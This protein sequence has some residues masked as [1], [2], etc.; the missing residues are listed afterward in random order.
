MRHV[1]AK[2]TFCGV[3]GANLNFPDCPDM[4]MGGGAPGGPR[5]TIAGDDVITG[6]IVG[7]DG[8]GRMFGI[9]RG[10]G[11]GTGCVMITSFSA[12]WGGGGDPRLGSVIVVRRG[13]M[14]I[15]SY[16]VA[17]R[18]MGSLPGGSWGEIARGWVGAR[19]GAGG[20]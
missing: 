1:A 7:D 6:R 2:A 9:V 11:I 10:T 19:G 16:F 18:G 14:G 12:R 15:G 4:E 17:R 20:L 13:A 3:A 8:L 5:K